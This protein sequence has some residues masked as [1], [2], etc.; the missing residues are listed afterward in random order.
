MKKRCVTPRDE[1]D[2]ELVRY[3]IAGLKERVE[4]VAAEARSIT[5]A[6]EDLLRVTR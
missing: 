3:R 5:S 6:L 4:K 1:N 2:M